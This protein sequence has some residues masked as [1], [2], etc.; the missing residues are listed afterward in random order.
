MSSSSFNISVRK[1]TASFAG[2]SPTDYMRPWDQNLFQDALI[3]SFGGSWAHRTSTR[4]VTHGVTVS[5]AA[6]DPEALARIRAEVMLRV[7]CH[8]LIDALP[9]H[10]L[11]N[12][13][14]DI[15]DIYRSYLL[16]ANYGTRHLMSATGSV[17]ARF[18]AT[19]VREPLSYSDEP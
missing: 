5:V 3:D 7:F 14:E 16:R 9:E 15:A 19:H 17:P 6:G 12:A 13:A 10:M 11:A 1:P 8:Q 4:Q 2:A 18:G